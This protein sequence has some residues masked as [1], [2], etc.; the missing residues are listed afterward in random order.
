MNLSAVTFNAK[1]VLAAAGS[2]LAQLAGQ[3]RE[4]PAAAQAGAGQQE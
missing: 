3:G 4:Q 1:G 2:P